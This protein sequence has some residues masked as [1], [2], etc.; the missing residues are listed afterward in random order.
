MRDFP[1]RRTNQQPLIR[2]IG[3]RYPRFGNPSTNAKGLGPFCIFSLSIGRTVGCNV[4]VY[5]PVN[6]SYRP[7]HDDTAL[8]V[9]HRRIPVASKVLYLHRY[10]TSDRSL[11]PKSNVMSSTKGKHIQSPKPTGQKKEHH[12]ATLGRFKIS[13]PITPFHAA[14]AH[15]MGENLVQ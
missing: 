9:R 10:L 7:S 11:H 5:W 1:P 3:S 15:E 14:H 6:D 13:F 12:G 8:S 2:I 4:N